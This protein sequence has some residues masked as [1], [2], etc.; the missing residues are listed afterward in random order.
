MPE[1]CR[2]HWASFVPSGT[3]ALL[4]QHG[5]WTTEQRQ[6][7]QQQTQ[8]MGHRLWIDGDT[9]IRGRQ[10]LM[11]HTRQLAMQEHGRGSHLHHDPG[12]VGFADVEE[13]LVVPGVAVLLH[14][15]LP[16][17][18][19]SIEHQEVCCPALG[20]VVAEG[21][22]SMPEEGPEQQSE[23]ACEL[24]SVAQRICTLRP[25]TQH[26]QGYL[27]TWPVLRALHICCGQFS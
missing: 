8:R 19:G 18:R 4:L 2:A 1:S 13:D 16:L 21:D 5:L 14:I 10:L 20:V 24:A 3:S 22:G 17:T 23:S 25:F 7:Q 11:L 27:G 9:A 12:M 26:R 6:Q 15:M